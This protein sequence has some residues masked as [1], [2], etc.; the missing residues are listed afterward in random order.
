MFTTVITLNLLSFGMIKCLENLEEIEVWNSRL[1][2]EIIEGEEVGGVLPLKKLPF[3]TA[4]KPFSL[5]HITGS[6]QWWDSLDWDE[7]SAKTCLKPFFKED[8]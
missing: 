1:I 2:E 8:K 4:N 6:K 3:S 5:K 7:S